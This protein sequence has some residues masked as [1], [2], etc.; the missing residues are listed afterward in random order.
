MGGL[1]LLLKNPL[2][3]QKAIKPK[4]ARPFV[5]GTLDICWVPVNEKRSGS[6]LSVQI[7]SFLPGGNE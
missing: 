1:K 7:A 3:S 6:H 4:G 2:L 5:G